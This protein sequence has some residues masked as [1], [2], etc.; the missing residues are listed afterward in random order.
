MNS[1]DEERLYSSLLSRQS[2]R[3]TRQ[4]S[5]LWNVIRVWLVGRDWQHRVAPRGSQPPHGKPHE[6]RGRRGSCAMLGSVCFESISSTIFRF[7]RALSLAGSRTISSV[8]LITD[9]QWGIALVLFS[10]FMTQAKVLRYGSLVRALE[11]GLAWKSRSKR[12]KVRVRSGMTRG[13]F[14][15][16]TVNYH[17]GISSR[18]VAN[19]TADSNQFLSRPDHWETA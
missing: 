9:A 12:E 3:E 1:T 7:A 17:I 14:Q 6:R 15:R 18:L 10:W 13:W 11:K 5:L 2:D 19:Q 8:F 16:Q 4:I